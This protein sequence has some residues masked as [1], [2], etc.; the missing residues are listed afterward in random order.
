[1]SIEEREEETNEASVVEV[2]RTGFES[3]MLRASVVEVE[4]FDDQ[5]LCESKD[6]AKLKDS[7]VFWVESG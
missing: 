6:G 7:R 5:G 3:D 4:V 1:L 2:L